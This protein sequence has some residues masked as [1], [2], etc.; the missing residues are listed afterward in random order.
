M[1]NQ[2][3]TKLADRLEHGA[4][5]LG[6]LVETLSASEWQTRL[7]GDNRKI[8]TVVHHVATVY[9]IEIHLAVT[10]AAGLPITGLTMNEVHEM[11][12]KHATEWEQVSVGAALDLLRRNS[13]AAADA[14]R[15][16]SDP[17]LAQAATVSLYADAPVTCQFVLED[18]A[19]RHSYHHL[20]AIRRA[21]KR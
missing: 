11:N 5:A 9:P 12:A 20:A 6:A 19:V 2:R 16:L 3:A 15:A 8:G 10:V 21:L 17:Q 18:H 14:I 4:N 13:A 1:M 7:P